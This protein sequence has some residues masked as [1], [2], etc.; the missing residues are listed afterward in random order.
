MAHHKHLI[1]LTQ[2]NG[3]PIWI[4]KDKVCTLKGEQSAPNHNSVIH[5]IT[6]EVIFVKEYAAGLQDDLEKC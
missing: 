4:R 5:M 3:S 1:K 2:E 6:G